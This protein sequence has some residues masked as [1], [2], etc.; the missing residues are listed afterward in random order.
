MEAEGRR[1]SV[2]GDVDV[3]LPLLVVD[4]GDEDI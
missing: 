1:F 4:D 3:L 2:N